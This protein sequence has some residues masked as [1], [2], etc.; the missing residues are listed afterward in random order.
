MIRILR[1][2]VW[3]RW[4]TL[5]NSLERRT[6]RDTLERFSIAVEQLAPTIAA[7]VLL[8]SMI[9]LA[10]L[11][12]Y[13]GWTLARGEPQ[14]FIFEALRFL[15]LAACA[16]AVAG[17]IMLPGGDRTNAV[18][19]LLLPIP[20]G[21]LYLGHA[22]GAL[23]DPWV[24]L[25]TAAV[26]GLPLGLA[27]GGSVALAVLAAAAGLLLIAAL[28]GISLAVSGAAHLFVRDRRRGELLALPWSSCCR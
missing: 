3:L 17:P 5:L 6:S 19:L 11:A 28:T 16:L 13:V 1:A 20:R 27:A 12:G 23:A 7:I 25:A 9:S 8:P 18:R 2:F 15:L 21:V 22:V 26:L 10:G 24:L 14:G 4:R